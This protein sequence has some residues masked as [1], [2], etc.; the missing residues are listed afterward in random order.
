[1]KGDPYA[2][3]PWDCVKCRHHRPRAGGALT[4]SYSRERIS[5]STFR[6]SDPLPAARDARTVSNAPSGGQGVRG[7]FSRRRGGVS[8]HIADQSG[9]H[10]HGVGGGLVVAKSSIVCRI[11]PLPP[12][13]GQIVTVDRE[14]VKQNRFF[15][16]AVVVD[17]D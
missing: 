3:G 4:D 2:G 6:S 8:F 12:E 5:C 1:M 17:G 15:G 14:G 13:S 9:H 10:R 11:A 16:D 7:S